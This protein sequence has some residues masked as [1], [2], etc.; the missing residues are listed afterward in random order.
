MIIRG[1]SVTYI[2]KQCDK[3]RQVSIYGL[4][5]DIDRIYDRHLKALNGVLCD[6]CRESTLIIDSVQLRTDQDTLLRWRIDWRCKACDRVW[7]QLRYLS[8]RRA[9][10]SDFAKKAKAQTSCTCEDE[11]EDFFI[12]Q[13]RQVHYN[14]T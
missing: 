1:L 5:E 14:N 11:E 3:T 7:K 8:R 9:F 10:G 13:I 12:T 4:Y 6:T 2:C